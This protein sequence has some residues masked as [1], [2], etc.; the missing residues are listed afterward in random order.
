MGSMQLSCQKGYNMDVK[1]QYKTHAHI[2]HRVAKT[3]DNIYGAKPVSNIPI[4]KTCIIAF[5]GENTRTIKDANYYASMLNQL[6][7]FYNLNVVDVY[8]V[9]YDFEDKS[10]DRKTERQNA[11]IAARAKILNKQDVSIQPVDT[12][13]I[14]DLY[15]IIIRPRIADKNGVKLPDKEALQ[16]MRNCIF[17]THCHG[18]VPVYTFQ[19]MMY[20]DM[21]QLGYDTRAIHNIMKNLLVIQHAPVAPLEKSKFNTISFMSANDTYMNF[22]DKFSAYLADN[23][24]DLLPSYFA[25][26]N[27][28]AV[29]GFTYQLIDEHQITGL[30]P[31]KNQDM[32]TPD[33]A[34][35]MAAERNTIINGINAAKHSAP[36][37]A[38]RDLIAPANKSDTVRPDF[39]TLSEN[40]EFFMRLMHHDLQS[41][42]SKDR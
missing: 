27:L 1:T 20:Q 9:Y 30:V 14:N 10:S 28:F 18:A 35:I 34:I 19:R 16:N 8:S 2:M 11:F 15:K 33:G 26:N 6:V 24:A 5:G 12:Q 37:P 40:G 25:S 17:Y 31:T 13:Y 36:V 29:Y 7:E 3:D 41:I 22:Y 39:K 21:H 42:K 4:N 32:L 38:I 23:N